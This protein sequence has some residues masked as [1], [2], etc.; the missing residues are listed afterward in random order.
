MHKGGTSFLPAPCCFIDEAF[1]QERI[2]VVGRSTKDGGD[3]AQCSHV[4]LRGMKARQ[5]ACQ[6]RLDVSPAVAEA[7][8]C[9]ALDA[10][11]ERKRRGGHV[12]HGEIVAVEKVECGGDAMCQ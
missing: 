6:L 11:Q 1:G 7:D 10:S 9:I 2:D 12:R 8:G 4:M 5:G 3:E